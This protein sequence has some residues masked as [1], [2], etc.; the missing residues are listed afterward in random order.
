MNTGT[1]KE[2]PQS[3]LNAIHSSEGGKMLRLLRKRQRE[4]DMLNKKKE[5]LEWGK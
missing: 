4:V 1:Q 3:L 5:E 2:T